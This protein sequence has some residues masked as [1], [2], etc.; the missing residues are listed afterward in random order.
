MIPRVT[1]EN[2]DKNT[3]SE[4]SAASGAAVGLANAPAD[5]D[6]QV[7]I[8]AWADLYDATLQSDDPAASDFTNE[9]DRL[10]FEHEGLTIWWAMQLALP[11]AEIS[12]FSEL[13]QRLYT[14]Q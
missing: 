12:Y 3:H 11:D 9:T 6:L 2:P 5:P 13:F 7:I 10:S 4:N 14:P 8:E 1:P